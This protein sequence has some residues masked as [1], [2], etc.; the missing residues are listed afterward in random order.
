M[1]PEIWMIPAFV[2]GMLWAY[3]VHEFYDSYRGKT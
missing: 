2:G 3:I 1:I